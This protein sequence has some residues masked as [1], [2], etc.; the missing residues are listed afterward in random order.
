MAVLSKIRERSVLLIAV[1]GFCLLAFIIGDLFQSGQFGMPSRY[2]GSVNGKD[3]M[4]D[5]FL[6]KKQQLEQQGMSST[7]AANQVWNQEVSLAIMTEQFDKLGFRVGESHLIEGLKNDPEI[8]QNQLFLNALGEFDFNKFKEY[9]A[10]NPGQEALVENKE[11]NI[12]L[13]AKYRMYMD[14]VRAAMYTTDLEGKFKY[15]MSND[16]V[17][18]D[19]VPVMYS[20]VKDSEVEVKDDEI[21]AFMKKYPKRF[22]SEANREFEYV[23]FEDKPSAEDEAEIKKNIDLL[24][25]GGVKN[26]VTIPAF[27]SLESD[28]VA[29]FVNEHSDVPFEDTYIPKNNLPTEHAESLFNLPEGGIY[30]PYMFGNYYCISR[31]MGKTAGGNAKASHILIAFDGTNVPGQKEPRTKE[32]A[33]AKAEALLAQA[34]ANPAG[35]SALASANSE[36]QG[37]A[38]K[39]GDLGFFGKGQMVPAFNDYV[40]NNGIGSIGLVETNFGYHVIYITDKEDAIQLATIA[41]RIQPSEATSNAIFQKASQFEMDAEK[42]NFAEL[43]KASNLDVIPAR[44]RAYDESFGGLS[45]QRAIVQWVF[46]KSTDKGDVKKFTVANVGEVV[47]KVKSINE[48]GLMAV[49][50]ARPLV[51][52]Q[53]KNE[54]KA[55]IILKKIKGNSLADIATATGS[56]V[57][58]IAN[59][60]IE[61]PMLPNVG[62]EPKVVAQAIKTGANKLSAPIVGQMGVYVVQPQAVE[63]APALKN[64]V[65]FANR[66]KGMKQNY[67]GRFL[68]ALRDKAKIEDF[69]SDLNL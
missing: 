16:R 55:A 53:L 34:K 19:F 5:E 21:I 58:T 66:A 18:F 43:A 17:T 62:P 64:H 11:K 2:V 44:V 25:N 22:K 56:A 47:V 60:S 37:S 6:Q 9:F 35:F 8:G 12:I 33:K 59:V 23:V 1:I 61:Q 7:Q 26:G 27:A 52:N 32:E 14:M 42:G 57:Q 30:G 51:E 13:N 29:D 45:N 31:S 46:N 67:A 10:N 20:T 3:I 40:F 24:V 49:N 48:E 38:V 68:P 36:D 65:E 41:Q 4:V 15:E 28:K 54:K 69:R 39:G 50:E 63:K